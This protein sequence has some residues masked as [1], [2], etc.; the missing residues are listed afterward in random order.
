MDAI[1]ESV[2]PQSL[3]CENC[4]A[5][6][7]NTQKFCSQ[8]SFPENGTSDEKRVFRTQ[9]NSRKRFIRDAQEKVKSTKVIMFVLAGLFLVV[10][11][12]MGFGSDDFAGMVTN[13][14][15]CLVFLI[16]AAWCTHNPFGATLTALI[17]YCTLLVFN[18]FVDPSTIVS[19]IVIKVA[20]I[21]TLVKGIRSAQQAQQ[22]LKEL[23]KIKA[24]PLDE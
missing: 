3:I 12:Y 10:G 6:V 7:L 19:G 8:C 17:I 14:F 23:E 18:A 4:S 16:L 11:I 5:P 21:A 24:A 2:D 15:L 13:T 22:Y 1:S 9:V 20:I